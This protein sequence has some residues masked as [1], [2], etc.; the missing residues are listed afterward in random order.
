MNRVSGGPVET[1]TYN[2]YMIGCIYVC[3]LPPPPN[4][5]NLFMGTISFRHGI[6]NHMLSLGF[7]FIKKAPTTK[8]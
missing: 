7:T 4:A 2:S 8:R 6:V 5:V 1:I 3:I